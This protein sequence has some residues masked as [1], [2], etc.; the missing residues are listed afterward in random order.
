[1]IRVKRLVPDYVAA[2]PFAQAAKE[3][4]VWFDGDNVPRPYAPPFIRCSIR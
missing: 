1:M 4:M 3:I 2:I